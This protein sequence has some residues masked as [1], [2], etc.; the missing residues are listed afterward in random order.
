[1]EYLVGRTGLEPV[2]SALSKQ[3]SEPTELTVRSNLNQISAGRIR[4]HLTFFSNSTMAISEFTRSRIHSLISGLINSHN[5]RL[6]QFPI[7]KLISLGGAPN[8]LISSPK[9]V[10]FEIRITFPRSFAFW[11]ITI[12]SRLLCCHP[13][14]NSRGNMRIKPYFPFR[15]HE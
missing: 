9:S 13:F 6:S 8:R 15:L 10:S 11:K 3:R 12:S 5:V 1:M 2:T 14:S 7:C 4:D